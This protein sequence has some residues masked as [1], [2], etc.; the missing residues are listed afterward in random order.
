MHARTVPNLVL[1]ATQAPLY[2]M[3]LIGVVL[4]LVRWQNHP[5]VSLLMMI[6]LG[7]AGATPI[8]G[9]ALG[10]WFQLAI[11]AG[12]MPALYVGTFLAAFNSVRSLL[13]AA[14]IGLLLAAAFVERPQ[15]DEE[16]V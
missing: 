1:L 16:K 12:R 2:V 3:W 4:A 13:N 10:M 7:V 14:A 5:R 15:A 8:V 9:A 11:D 6:G